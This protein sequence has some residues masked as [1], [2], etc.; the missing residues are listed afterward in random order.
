M[1][2]FI[3]IEIIAF[4]DIYNVGLYTFLGMSW[5]YLKTVNDKMSFKCNLY[6]YIYIYRCNLYIYIYK[7]NF[8]IYIYIY[9]STARTYNI[10]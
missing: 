3:F 8:Y 10:S 2:Y 1:Y 4:H 6:I 7:C 5:S 9:I